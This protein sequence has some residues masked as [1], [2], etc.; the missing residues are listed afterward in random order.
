LRE[1]DDGRFVSRNHMKHNSTTTKLQQ[2][3]K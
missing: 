3:G 2:L 1:S